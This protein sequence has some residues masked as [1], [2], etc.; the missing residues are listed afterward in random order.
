MI[1][2][3]L[4]ATDIDGTLT[5]SSGK[6]DLKVVETLRDL[7]ASGVPVILVSGR[8][9]PFVE[10]LALYIGTSG[11]IIAENGA[12]GIISGQLRQFGDPEP[13][14]EALAVL[15]RHFHFEFDDDNR[16]RIVDVTLKKSMDPD[17]IQR[18]IT[19]KNLP[20]TLL[21]TNVMLH[22]VDRKVSKGL[23]VL[24][25]LESLGIGANQAVVCGDSYN[26]IPLF[27]IGAYNL[28]AGNGEDV[29][30][31]KADK[32]AEVPFGAGLAAELRKL[33]GLN[34]I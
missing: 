7:E 11:P 13:A 34:R 33:F 24:K 25:A 28:A 31:A 5:D 8:P 6:L 15:E 32:V 2:F 30:K 1:N 20:V 21:V 17:E 12:V 22:L 9:L 14:R 29:L 26:D 18:I 4:L 27:E 23:S 19:E 10:S 3:K 16:Y